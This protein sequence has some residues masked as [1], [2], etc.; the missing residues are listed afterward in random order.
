MVEA[1]NQNP[2]QDLAQ[3]LTTITGEK[4]WA[5]GCYVPV[6]NVVVCV[7]AAVKMINSRF[8]LFHARQGLVLFVLWF[9][10]IIVAF[11]SPV[12]SLMLWGVVLLLHGSGMVIAFNMKETSIPVIGQFAMRI[13]EN[14]LFSFLTGKKQDA[15]VA[16]TVDTAITTGM[17]G[18]VK[19][20]G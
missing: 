7:L 12:L 16:G 11:F 13:P 2:V 3:K 1:P 6:F 10:T 8:C 20:N 18:V 15:T 5:M 14:Y 9:F 17:D 4:R 19:K